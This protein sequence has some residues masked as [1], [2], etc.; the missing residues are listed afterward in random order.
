L[1]VDGQPILFEKLLAL[2]ERLWVSFDY[3]GL[4]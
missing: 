4:K 1:P 3:R 2:D